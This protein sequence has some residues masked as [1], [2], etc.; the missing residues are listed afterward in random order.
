MSTFRLA[1]LPALVV[2]T[3]GAGAAVAAIPGAGPLITGAKPVAAPQGTVQGGRPAPAQVAVKPTRPNP[4]PGM[5]PAPAFS[6][7]PAGGGAPVTLA[8]FKGKVVILDFWATWCPPCRE[9]IPGFV[10]LYNDYKARGVVVVG[11]SVDRG[12]PEVVKQFMAQNGINYPSLMADAAVQQAYGGI[13]SIPTTFVIDRNG[14]LQKKFV[15]GH[16]MSTFEE[17]I[18][19]LL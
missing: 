9:E 7:S 19:P 10:K 2:A 8:S 3:M 14:N 4:G 6:L 5:G 12:G 1:L 15:G 17:A 18:K 13:R 16:E 11:V